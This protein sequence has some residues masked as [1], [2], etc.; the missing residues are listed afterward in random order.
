[1]FL[2]NRNFSDFFD[3]LKVSHETCGSLEAKISIFDDFLKLTQ[4]HVSGVILPEKD[5]KMG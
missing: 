2:E 3:F 5:E 4:K 1:M